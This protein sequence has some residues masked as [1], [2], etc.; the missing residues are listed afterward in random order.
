MPPPDSPTYPLPKYVYKILPAVPPSPLPAALPL[1]ALDAQDGFIHLSTAAQ[2]PV[3][4]RLFFADADALWIL[5]V[6]AAAAA[7]AGGVFRWVEGMPGCPH[8]YAAEDGRWV[9]LGSATVRGQREV[10]RAEGQGWEDAFRQLE[11]WMV[12]G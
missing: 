8:L 4:A 9:D 7:G 5:R 6:D 10:R 1:S 11:G 3:T 2:V 12:D